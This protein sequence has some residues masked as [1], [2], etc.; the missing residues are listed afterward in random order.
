ML[1]IKINYFS[2]YKGNIVDEI[3][4]KNRIFSEFDQF[5]FLEFSDNKGNLDVIYSDNSTG[6]GHV[7]LS[8]G[9]KTPRILNTLLKGES[10]LFSS[11]KPSH[12]FPDSNYL[13]EKGI[14]SAAIIPLITQETIYGVYCFLS[15]KPDKP[16]SER[17]ILQFHHLVKMTA[18][19][20]AYEISLNRT[21]ELFKFEQLVAE[22]S[23]TYVNLPANE[24]ENTIEYGLSRI[25]EF[26]HSDRCALWKFS[27]D[28]SIFQPILFWLR[29]K[30]DEPKFRAAIQRAKV[31]GMFDFAFKKWLSG[32]ALVLNR[33][34]NLPEEASAYKQYAEESGQ[35][36][37]ISVPFS[38]AGS[39]YG[40]IVNIDSS[41]QN[42]EE[43]IPRLRLIG[44]IFGNALQRKENEQKLLAAYAETKKL[45]D[46]IE[47]DYQYLRD[48]IHN[49]ENIVGE[50]K[51]LKLVFSDVENVACTD[52]TV[53]ITGETGTGKELIARAI[54]NAS[55]RR[56]RPLIIVNCA[57]FSP[58]LI[59]NELFGHEKGAFT[60]A[61]HRQIGRFE[62][63]NGAT[64]F[65]DEIGD[66]PLELQPKLL[67]V[68]Q[69]GSFERL[70][71]SRTIKTDARVIAATNQDMVELVKKGHFRRD[72]WYRI[73]VFNIKIPPL[74]ERREDIPLLVEW[75]IKKHSRKFGK[76]IKSVTSDSINS[77]KKYDWPG[78]IRELEHVVEHAIIATRGT[79]LHIPSSFNQIAGI[80]NTEATKRSLE[81][82]ERD[83]IVKMLE[84]TKGK[85][86][87]SEGAADILKI[88][89]ATLYS[90]MKKLG[91][92]KKHATYY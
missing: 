44:D 64:I 1:N 71:G 26:L 3:V 37:Q 38:V 36:S 24:V 40:A 58:N 27:K 25:G 84:E 66:L 57:S 8:I 45:K 9:D 76:D 86:Y 56:E 82:I 15:R 60:D 70:G 29:E 18:D 63:A 19:R 73:N 39:I 92:K 35:K 4:E 42:P 75:F 79:T 16:F 50:S 10:V 28:E 54:H 72:L 83:H 17:D 49:F 88:N 69:D 52:T 7:L 55:Q 5:D 59:E 41:Y 67:R 51:C 33:F 77:L 91:I 30:K 46:K 85:I 89:P 14:Y 6:I 22:I 61:K 20:I 11:K 32:E 81:E 78:N 62:L 90:R 2:L 43:I 13:L 80:Y 23:A 65:L 53:L 87:G 74:R 31:N 47:A 21:D 34:N 48:E 68:L 12:I